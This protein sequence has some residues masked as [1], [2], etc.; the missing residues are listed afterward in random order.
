M[1]NNSRQ[2]QL[3]LRHLGPIERARNRRPEKPR[4]QP[5]VLPPTRSIRDRHRLRAGE[6]GGYQLQHDDRQSGGASRGDA[7]AARSRTVEHRPTRRTCRAGA[8]PTSVMA[9]QGW[10]RL[11][12]RRQRRHAYFPR[13]TKK[14]D[15]FT[16]FLGD[17]CR[18]GRHF[19]R[20][21]RAVLVGAGQAD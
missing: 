1:A 13:R 2:Q 14:P 3:D 10:G 8:T 18:K 15:A 16:G 21:R 7:S 17:A 9:P 6:I 4:A 11:D 19:A 20:E 12:P 5:K